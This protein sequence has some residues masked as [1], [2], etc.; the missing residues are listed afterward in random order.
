MKKMWFL[1]S[2]SSHT[3]WCESKSLV[4]Q[5]GATGLRILGLEGIR[6][7]SQLKPREGK[8]QNC[9]TQFI[10]EP[11][12]PVQA[13][14]TVF[15]GLILVLFC[16]AMAKNFMPRRGSAR[17]DEEAWCGHPGAARPHLSSWQSDF[18]K[19]N[20]GRNLNRATTGTGVSGL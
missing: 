4:M 16:S 17:A 18:I 14:F 5:C 3:V 10:T 11:W 15:S 12:G 7:L 6:V 20:K 8:R 9:V 13:L 2:Q 1:P 19:K